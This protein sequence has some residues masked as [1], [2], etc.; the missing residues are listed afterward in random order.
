MV[1]SIEYKAV[2]I[3]LNFVAGNIL[4]CVYYCVLVEWTVNNPSI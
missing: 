3:V 1:I 2:Y 4:F